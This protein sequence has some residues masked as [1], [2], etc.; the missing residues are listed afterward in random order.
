[1]TVLSGAV[2]SSTMSSTL[3]ECTKFDEMAAAMTLVG[4]VGIRVPRDL[5]EKLQKS[6][7]TTIQGIIAQTD[8][9]G[10]LVLLLKQ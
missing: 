3:R 5:L 4:N 7:Q 1:M 8:K 2:G 10:E 6:A 9:Q